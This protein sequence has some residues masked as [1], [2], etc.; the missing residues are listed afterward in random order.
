MCI[1]RRFAE[2]ELGIL[3]I[4]ALQTFRL[5]YSGAEVGLLLSF[6]NKP[7]RMVNIKFSDR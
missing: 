2:L 7:D 6:T 1:G 4:R 5:S 3:A